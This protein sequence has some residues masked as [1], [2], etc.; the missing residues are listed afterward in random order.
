MP[1]HFSSPRNRARVL[2]TSEEW[3]DY[4]QTNATSLRPIPW[5]LGVTFT[6]TEKRVI[7]ASL[8]T[9]QLGETGEGKHIRRCADRYALQSG[10]THY[11]LA[12][13]RF[14]DE[15][16]RHAAELGKILDAAGIPR[17]KRHW[18]DSVFR[19]LRHFGGL[20]LAISVL[21]TAELIAKIY[22]AALRDATCSPVLRALC[23]QILQDEV[24]HVRFQTERLA[25][26]RRGRPR[27]LIRCAQF[28]QGLLF[29]STC[30]AF[31]IT[32]RPVMR[33][34][35]FPFPRFL[36]RARHEFLSALHTM[37]PAT[38]VHEQP[39]TLLHATPSA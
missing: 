19:R 28:L 6:D 23:E 33:A 26:L 13:R 8:Q 31:W 24:A 27:F 17:L 21:L 36:R 30:A 18:S 34:G 4:F 20:E 22:Y 5:D 11:P 3:C 29:T 16:H 1:P 10:D 25:L 15:E 7:A 14:I 37:N 38:Y 32:H 2:R 9:F 12:L 35:G 39:A